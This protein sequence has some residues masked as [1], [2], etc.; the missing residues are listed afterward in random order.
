MCQLNTVLCDNKI[1]VNISSLLDST[2]HKKHGSLAYH[3]V[4]WAVSSGVVKIVWVDTK[5]N[6]DDALNKLLSAVQRY[7]LF[8]YWTY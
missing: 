4:R 7:D 5:L 2:L 1:A 3:A 8:G 6:I